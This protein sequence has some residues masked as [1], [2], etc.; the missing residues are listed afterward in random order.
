MRTRRGAGSSRW[1]L[2][3]GYTR[4][5]SGYD[6][7]IF[8]STGENVL[9]VTADAVGSQWV[10][11]RAKYEFADRSGSGLNED[12]LVEIGEQ[13][14][15]RHYDVA[16]RTPESVHGADGCA[17]PT[18]GGLFSVSA[19]FGTDDYDDSY[20]GLQESTFRT[21]SLGADLPAAERLRRR[22]PA[23]TTSATRGCSNRD[24]RARARK[25]IRCATGRLIR[26]SA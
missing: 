6:F 11:F 12:L 17:C 14:A 19:G 8:D 20:F 7:R 23:T 1:R 13:P 5:N 3:A 10:T 16:D 4:N 18:T 9:R 2:S 22:A 21:F 25:T 26:P 24:R 15:M